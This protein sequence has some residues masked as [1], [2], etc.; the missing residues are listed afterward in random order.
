MISRKKWIFLNVL[1]KTQNQI[2]VRLLISNMQCLQTTVFEGNDF[3]P[4]EVYL[5]KPPIYWERDKL[6]TI[7]ACKD[8]DNYLPP[9]PSQ[10][11]TW[12]C[13]LINERKQ[14]RRIQEIWEM[15]HQHPG[16]EWMKDPGLQLQSRSWKQP[17]HIG[18]GWCKTPGENPLE[19][20]VETILQLLWVRDQKYQEW[21]KG[22]K[23]QGKKRLLEFQET[24]SVQE[25]Y[26]T[27]VIVWSKTPV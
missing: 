9:S 22:Q 15:V 13:I 26:S 11:V 3:Q 16:K 4:R 1:Q 14:E 18:A 10:E 8:L 7:L 17:V 21:G 12:G 19:N 6:H 20:K 24:K 25:M 27:S 23:M 5:A 2:G